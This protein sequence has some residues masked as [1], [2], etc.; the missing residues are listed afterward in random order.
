MLALSVRRVQ[1]GQWGRK[2]YKVRRGLRD[3]RALRERLARRDQRGRK[4]SLVP[5]AFKVRRGRAG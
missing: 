2:D 1:P 4:V 3:S 5:K